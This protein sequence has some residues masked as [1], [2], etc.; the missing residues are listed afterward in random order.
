MIVIFN[1]SAAKVAASDS[2]AIYWEARRTVPVQETV[3]DFYFYVQWSEHPTDGFANIKY[4]NGSD[5]VIDGAIG[6]LYVVH[7]RPHY[8]HSKEYYYKVVAIKKSDASVVQETRVVF[9][10]NDKDGI[11]ETIRYAE[12]TLYQLYVGEPVR[13]LKRRID[14]ER[15]WECWNPYSFRRTKTHCPTCLS[16][17]FVDGYYAPIPIQ[18]A[19]DSNPKVTEV[20]QTGE[21]NLTHLRARMSDFPLVSNRD[22]IVGLD[23]NDRYQIVN[24]EKTKLPNLACGR[25]AI[26]RNAHTISQL[27]TLSEIPPSDDRYKYPILGRYLVGRG[28]TLV[29][30]ISCSGTSASG[31]IGMGLTTIES[32]S[33]SGTGEA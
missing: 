2:Y 19:F 15:C 33:G 28:D 23:D 32:V 27:L 8:S 17:G 7:E 14:Q 12:A 30:E 24:V 6:P 20:G 5:V 1:V 3:G 11:I 13:L 21:Q 9:T 16:T 4:T 18:I 29:S 31:H 25:D 26:S 22:L 10:G